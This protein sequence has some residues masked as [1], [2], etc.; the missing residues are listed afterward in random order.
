VENGTA[1]LNTFHLNPMASADFFVPC[2]GRPRSIDLDN[3]NKLLDRSDDQSPLSS[4]KP[5]CSSLKHNHKDNLKYKYIVEGANLFLTEDA[6]MILEQNGVILFKDASANKGG[7]TS[8][9]LE[10]LAGLAMTGEEHREHMCVKGG[11]IPKFYEEY[12]QEVI[13]IIRRNASLEFN[14]LWNASNAPDNTR[15]K[16]ELTGILSKKINLMFDRLMA[17]P[18]VNKDGVVARHVLAQGLP[19]TLV[20]L[21][22]L[23]NILKRVPANYLTAI[24][25]A[26]LSARYIYEHGLD[27]DE[28]SFFKFIQKITSIPIAPTQHTPSSSPHGK[29]TAAP[30]GGAKKA[31]TVKN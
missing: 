7:V 16:T 23:E 30:A 21:L 22:G 28:I 14:V 19:K 25:G 26:Q 15:T 6:R 2:G 27:A 11:K 3:V 4:L 12:V 1:F 5:T 8:S 13:S 24:V 29:T 31:S 18:V 17:S 20:N 10:V 9:S